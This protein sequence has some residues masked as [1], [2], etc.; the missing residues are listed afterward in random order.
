MTTTCIFDILRRGVLH[1]CMHVYMSSI[2]FFNF[3][4]FSYGLIFLLQFQP[5]T[6]DRKIQKYYELAE[7]VTPA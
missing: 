3:A 2:Y 7:W 4:A 1:A 6:E 5:I